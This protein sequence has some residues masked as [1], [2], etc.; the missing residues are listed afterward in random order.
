MAYVLRKCFAGDLGLHEDISY[1][2][3]KTQSSERPRTQRK[4]TPGVAHDATPRQT[5]QQ[6]RREAPTSRSAHLSS[7]FSSLN[8][9]QSFVLEN[10]NMRET[11]RRRRATAPRPRDGSGQHECE[12]RCAPNTNHH[13]QEKKKEK[14]RRKDRKKRQEQTRKQTRRGKA[15]KQTRRGQRREKR[16]D[17]KEARR[18]ERRRK[19]DCL[20]GLFCLGP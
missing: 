10:I 12:N 1:F 9:R 8:A 16:R 18:G 19:G 5:K 15:R 2:K 14:E 20:S 6:K 4:T 7:P 13:Q 3:Q 11:V 17:R